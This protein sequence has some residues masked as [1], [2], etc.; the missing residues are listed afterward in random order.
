MN[1]TP[2]AYT[3]DPDTYAQLLQISTNSLV[4]VMDVLHT[5]VHEG[6]RKAV[7]DR[8]RGKQPDRR[9]F[10]RR[11]STIPAMLQLAEG[12][13]SFAARAVTIT[14]ISLGGASLTLPGEPSYILNY[15]D[16]K[17]EILFSLDEAKELILFTGQARRI[18][19]H[20]GG[21]HLGMLFT[22]GA[23]KDYQTLAA[24]LQQ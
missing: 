8:S 24:Y 23:F 5:F 9:R 19:E 1:A 18:S 22:D 17:I 10:L 12:K 21:S 15:D 14:D 3:P 6:I 16:A 11:Q 13:R 4:P 7:H 20:N 2:L